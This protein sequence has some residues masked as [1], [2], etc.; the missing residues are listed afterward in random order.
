MKTA[1]CEEMSQPQLCK[2][3][4]SMPA[5]LGPGAQQ[6]GSRCPGLPEGVCAILI[7]ALQPDREK[8]ITSMLEFG[9]GLNALQSSTQ[10]VEKSGGLLERLKQASRAIWH[11]SK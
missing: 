4:G 1:N 7:R 6:D 9:D 3:C 2:R 5:D 11:R 8:R 10:A